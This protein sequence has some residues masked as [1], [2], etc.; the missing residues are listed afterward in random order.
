M[1]IVRQIPYE[2]S[3]DVVQDAFEVLC[4]AK[5]FKI[6]SRYLPLNLSS[7]SADEVDTHNCKCGNLIRM[8][9]TSTRVEKAK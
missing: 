3:K 1:S 6:L 8:V 9:E 7:M 2:P 5:S 4:G